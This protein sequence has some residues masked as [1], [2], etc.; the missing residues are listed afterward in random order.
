MGGFPSF[1]GKRTFCAGNSFFAEF[2]I[3]ARNFAFLVKSCT[4]PV[5]GPQKTSQKLVFIKG[6]EQG[7]QKGAFGAQKC[8]FWPRTALLA[9]KPLIS[10]K[11]RGALENGGVLLKMHSILQG[12]PTFREGA[13]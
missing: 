13:K 11:W 7:T 12:I 6:F 9:K 4:F 5:L 2:R 1:C 10:L 8:F 3:L